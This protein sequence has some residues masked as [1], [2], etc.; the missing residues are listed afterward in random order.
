MEFY[1][2]RKKTINLIMIC[3]AIFVALAVIFVYSLGLFTNEV[4]PKGIALSGIFGLVLAIII[5]RMLIS[6]KDTAP[7]LV[8]SKEGI[9]ARVTAMSKAAGLILWQDIIDITINKVGGDTLVMLVINKPDQYT[10]LIRKKLSKLVLDGANDEH[11][12]LIVALTASE[13]DPD[14]QELFT[15]IKSY[16]AAIIDT[17]N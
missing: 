6:L 17:R 14:A 1:R 12:N 5:I 16:R 2:N 4:V 15:S 9:T 10:P 11:G 3:S 8:L 13:L 7:L